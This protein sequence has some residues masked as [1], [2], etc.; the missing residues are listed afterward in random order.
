M[1]NLQQPFPIGVRTGWVDYSPAL[2]HHITEKVRSRLAEFAKDIRS[3]SVRISD[4]EPHDTT[5]R[6]CSVEVTTRTGP[7]SASAVGADL[8]TVVDAAVDRAGKMLREQR[9]DVSAAEPRRL[10]A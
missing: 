1:Q 9:A 2:C 8:F 5:L 3:V 4:A 6:R 7:I 10:I